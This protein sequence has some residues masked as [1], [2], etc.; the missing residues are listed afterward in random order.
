MSDGIITTDWADPEVMAHWHAEVARRVQINL[1]EKKMSM[2]C[3]EPD[4]AARALYLLSETDM[5]K[6]AIAREVGIARQHLDRLAFNHAMSLEKRRPELAIKFTENAD[7]LA[8]LMSRKVDMLMEDEALLM[9]TPLK[10]IAIAM[11]V[12]IDKAGGLSGMATTVIEHRTGPSLEDAMKAISDARSRISEKLSGS[13]VDA[14]I[15]P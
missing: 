11:G 13:A 10:D 7:R 14:E 12:S 8:H 9:E 15:I 4:K 3:R 1:A 5:S 6:S 2:E